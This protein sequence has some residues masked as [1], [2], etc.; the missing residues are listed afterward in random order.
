MRLLEFIGIGR[1]NPP[2]VTFERGVEFYR[3]GNPAEAE[4]ICGQ[5]LQ[6]WPRHFEA[7]H[8]L[9]IIAL[10]AGRPAQA[11]E[12]IGKALAVKPDSAD[13]HCN[14][15]IALDGLGRPADA[16]ASYDKAIA[17]DPA[18]DAA[19]VNRS[20]PL[21][22]LER[23]AE[24]LASCDRAVTL[25]PASAEAHNN[26]GLALKGLKRRVEAL[27]SW[28]EAI[29]LKSDFADAYS[30]RGIVLNELKRHAEALAS[31]DKA[32]S[33]KPDF[34]NAHNNRGNA[35]YNLQRPSEALESYDKVLAL[36]P[37][38][39]DAHCNRGIAFAD[40]GRL[41]DAAV[42]CDRAI[43]LKPDNAEAYFNKSCAALL[44]GDF[45]RGW[46]LYEWRKKTKNSPATRSFAEPV[47]TGAE[48][49][50]GKTLFVHWEQGLGD[51]LQFCRYARLA[52]A[53]GATVVL[54]V[55]DALVRLLRT[56]SPTVTVIGGDARP[57]QFDYH[58]ALLSLPLAFGTVEQSIPAEAP[59]LSTD[60]DRAR[61]WKERLG[62]HGFKVGIAWQT[63]VRS[64]TSADMA[65]SFPLNR[66]EALSKIP[67][68][69]LI[70]LQKNDGVEQLDRMPAGM[71]VETLG[72]AY[73]KGPDGFVD[74]A[75]IVA[76]LDLVIT[77]DTAIAHLAGALGRPTW[78]V[79][80][81]VSD[82][83]WLLDRSDSPWYPTVRLFR[84]P[85]HRDW[86]GAFSEMEAALSEL[87]AA[88]RG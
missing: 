3:Q 66:F 10:Q 12:L 45:E 56:L 14:L 24:A 78:V 60:P 63:G 5:L 7:L 29:A 26:R 46:Q 72:E 80:K 43:A 52:E 2:Q 19:Y 47:W 23:F 50:F 69:R 40:L 49:L 79:L 20:V 81:H 70:S 32:I 9:G 22:A 86:A 16:L 87:C 33:L 38:F 77:A 85:A 62:D 53:R 27:Q 75:A 18:Y 6:R 68:V 41:A 21:M 8:L 88:A 36:R 84:Q 57:A 1:S 64:D 54:S 35:L 37:D 13:A 73:D 48:D 67:N 39:A 71:K 55:Q 83:R 59:Y 11:S 31:C 17:L 51:T 58:S 15:G 74:T 30:N 61:F 25:N 82:W 28:D 42:S 4:R 44:S 65:R 34:A 76:N